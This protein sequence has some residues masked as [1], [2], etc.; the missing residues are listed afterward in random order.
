MIINRLFYQT[1]ASLSI[2]IFYLDLI[3]IAHPLLQMGYRTTSPIRSWFCRDT[4][5]WWTPYR[6][7]QDAWRSRRCTAA[8]YKYQQNQYRKWPSPFLRRFARHASR[9]K[10]LRHPGLIR[11][12]ERTRGIPH[13]FPAHC[14]SGSTARIWKRQGWRGQW[15]GILKAAKV[16]S[17]GIPLF[18]L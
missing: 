13:P 4:S 12:K 16:F 2:L 7:R 14:T 8:G 9:K 11:R 18:L 3:Q 15:W 17:S 1:D 10:H 6:N 5:G